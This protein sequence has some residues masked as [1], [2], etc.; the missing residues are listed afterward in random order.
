MDYKENSAE[1]LFS[2]SFFA[3]SMIRTL[4]SFSSIAQSLTLIR[5]NKT[6]FD[7]VYSN[8]D[9][10]NFSFPDSYKI[11]N[12]DLKR[13]RFK[14][15]IYLNKINFSYDNEK[16]VIENL[17]LKIQKGD[18]IAILGKSGSGKST[19]IN[20]L[21]ALYKPTEGELSIDGKKINSQKETEIWQSQI[22]Y[23]SQD[24]YLLDESIKANIE[25]SSDDNFKLNEFEKAVKVAEIPDFINSLP[26]KYSSIVGDKGFKLSAGQ[27]QRISIARALYRNP[28]IL[29]LDEGTNSLDI[30]TE[31]KIF[32][33]LSKFYNNMTIILISHRLDTIKKC[34]KFYVC[35]NNSIY[36]I[37]FNELISTYKKLV[38]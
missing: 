11:E 6:Y 7:S 25:F 29:I 28:E 17:N 18:K 16:N 10:S 1:I 23:I 22:G 9:K 12:T 8:L 32:K 3:V 15:N 31:N 24:N 5:N 34:N 38:D 35:E 21:I 4:P 19:L 30:E 33:N 26:E 20:L 36:N 2:L 13:L 14:K 27:K 37:E